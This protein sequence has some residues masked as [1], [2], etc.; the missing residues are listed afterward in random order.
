MSRLVSGRISLAYLFAIVVCVPALEIGIS[1]AW[2]PIFMQ[3]SILWTVPF[4]FL[5]AALAITSLRSSGLIRV[6]LSGIAAVFIL[7]MWAHYR[8]PVNEDFRTLVDEVHAASR[9]GD[10]IVT[11]QPWVYAGVSYYLSKHSPRAL[12]VVDRSTPEMRRD[13]HLPPTSVQHLPPATDRIWF[14]GG[15]RDA[16]PELSAELAPYRLVRRY[17]EHGVSAELYQDTRVRP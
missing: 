14:I 7:D 1:L 5:L 4:F 9:D 2:R 10:V 15:L 11:G 6:I 8:K 16:D 13:G 3:R 17:D 12:I